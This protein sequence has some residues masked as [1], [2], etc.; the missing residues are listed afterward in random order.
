ARGSY[1]VVDGVGL[2]SH[3]HSL[4]G[5]A[6]DGAGTLYLA[7]DH[8]VR[9]IALA[10]ATVTTLAGLAGTSGSSDGVGTAARF[11]LTGAMIYDGARSLYVIDT[12]NY[13]IRKIALDTLTVSTVVG[14][15][16]TSGNVDGTGTAAQLSAPSGM[17]LYNGAIYFGDGPT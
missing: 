8:T 7:D 6:Y 14:T 17:T 13:T 3:F 1:D 10:T 2:T 9:Q 15:A 4:Q 5:M 16:A 11:N 12:L